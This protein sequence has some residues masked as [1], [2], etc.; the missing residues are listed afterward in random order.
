MQLFVATKPQICLLGIPI[1]FAFMPSGRLIRPIRPYCLLA[2]C[3]AGRLRI[4]VAAKQKIVLFQPRVVLVLASWSPAEGVRKTL[5]F[6]LVRNSWKYGHVTIIVYNLAVASFC[7]KNL[8]SW[9]LQTGSAKQ[10]LARKTNKCSA[11]GL[12]EQRRRTSV[13]RFFHLARFSGS[14][15]PD[16]AAWF[17]PHF[18]K[19]CVEISHLQ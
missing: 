18:M 14:L 19:S 8:R 2:R 9:Q 4:S 13:P 3:W 7:V 11:Q 10:P 17:S 12:F 6:C 16:C 15:Q 1:K 5:V